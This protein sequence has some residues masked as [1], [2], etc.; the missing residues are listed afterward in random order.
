MQQKWQQ[1]AEKFIE[2]SLRERAMLLSVILFGIVYLSYSLVIEPINLEAERLQAKI[3]QKKQ[4]KNQL[5]LDNLALIKTLRSD[6]NLLTKTQLQQAK[7]ALSQTE[8]EMALFTADL[9]GSTEM[10]LVLGEVLSKAQD[11]KLLTVES[12]PVVALQPEQP[13]SAKADKAEQKPVKKVNIYRHSLR[14]TL[15]GE[16]FAIQGYLNSIENLPKKLYW[17]VFDYELEEYP[18]AKVVMEFYTLSL[19]KEF[20]RG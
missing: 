5:T 15:S 6:P 7:I 14:M 11:V 1:L 20:I 8:A 9:I 12:L 13:S 16:Y 4:E 18:Q 10:A 17:Q 2:L 19:N 3:T